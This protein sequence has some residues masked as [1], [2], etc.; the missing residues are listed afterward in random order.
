MT[1]VF[2]ILLFFIVGLLRALVQVIVAW[3][4]GAR[5]IHVILGIGPAVF[6]RRILG[7]PVELR[8]IPLGGHVQWGE[9]A[10]SSTPPGPFFARA[11]LALA[12]PMAT[13]GVAFI[14]Q[15][16]VH[17]AFQARTVGGH[18]VATNVIELPLGSAVAQGLRPGDVLT[19]IDGQSIEF[20]DEVVQL[21][22]ASE[23][24]PMLMTVRRA[25]PNTPTPVLHITGTFQGRDLLGPKLDEEF[26][27]VELT[28]H[29]EPT[30]GVYRLGVEPTLARFGSESWGSALGL[31]ALEVSSHLSELLAPS[32]SF[33]PVRP[34]ADDFF[35][36]LFH[37]MI[38]AALCA[39]LS[40]LVLPAHDLHRLVLLVLEA[41]LRKPLSLAAELTFVRLEILGTLI[42]LTVYVTW[43]IVRVSA[44]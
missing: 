42:G 39:F 36:P 43:Y 31:S 13:L 6:H 22:Q 33:L 24:R 14:V 11:A 25:H 19:R 29:P 21:V 15:F 37:L 18:S 30:A 1:A 20:F 3:V 28:I 9:S 16:S 41:A 10:Y 27:I 8:V 38:I 26:Q 5:P 35:G 32:G 7:M 2:F 23:G 44:F 34:K 12:G 4:L 17:V 40:N